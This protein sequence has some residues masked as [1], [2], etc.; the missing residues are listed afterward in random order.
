[1]TWL[2]LHSSSGLETAWDSLELASIKF[3]N[4]LVDEFTCVV[5]LPRVT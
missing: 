2:E 1:M 4:Q 5:G 3:L